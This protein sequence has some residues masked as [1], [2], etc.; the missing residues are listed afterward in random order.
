VTKIQAFDANVFDADIRTWSVN[1]LL[2]LTIFEVLFKPWCVVTARSAYVRREVCY[3][4]FATVQYCHLIILVCFTFAAVEA[5]YECRFVLFTFFMRRFFMHG[6][7]VYVNERREC[8]VKYRAIILL[9]QISANG[10]TLGSFCNIMY[11]NTINAK[12]TLLSEKLKLHMRS[13]SFY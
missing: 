4:Y 9:Y 11:P 12:I 6:G 2:R 1:G 7:E 3:A 8:T 10:R 13:S 5:K